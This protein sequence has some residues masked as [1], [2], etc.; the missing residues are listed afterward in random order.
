V[1]SN[2]KIA[3]N[4]L[5]HDLEKVLQQTFFYKLLDISKEKPQ[6]KKDINNFHESK[7]ANKYPSLI[8][9]E[10]TKKCIDR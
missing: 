10:L 6:L 8:N 9:D 4:K 5:I 1:K 3:F 2:D 7:I